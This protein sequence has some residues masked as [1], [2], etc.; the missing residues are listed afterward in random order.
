MS[1]LHAGAADSAAGKDWDEVSGDTRA[2]S[3][4]GRDS[5]E[6]AHVGWWKWE[7]YRD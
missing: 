6:L 1:L 3:G 7:G 2:K 5:A 4:I